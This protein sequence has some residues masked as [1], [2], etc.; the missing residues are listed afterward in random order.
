MRLVSI[1]LVLAGCGGGASISTDPAV[2][3]SSSLCNVNSLGLLVVNVDYQVTLDV[4]QAF[5]ASVGPGVPVQQEN[6]SF[7]CSGLTGSFLGNEQ[8]GCERT[9]RS[10]EDTTTVEHQYNTNLPDVPTSLNVV[11]L[12]SVVFAPGSDMML[13]NDGDTVSCMIEASP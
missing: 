6:I 11:L 3:I 1:A 2:A 4:G 8:V 12:G 9:S 5:V 7:F 10:Q 13:A